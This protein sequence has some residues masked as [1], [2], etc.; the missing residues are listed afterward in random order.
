MANV[1][2]MTQLLTQS[3]DFFRTMLQQQHQQVQEMMNLLQTMK[4]EKWRR[5]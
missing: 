5:I 3:A 4:A 1:D 2:A